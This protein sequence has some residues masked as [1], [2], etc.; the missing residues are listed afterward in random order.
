MPPRDSE[1]GLASAALF[2]PSVLILE[3]L[4]KCWRVLASLSSPVRRTSSPPRRSKPSERIPESLT[5]TAIDRLNSVE[6]SQLA[7]A[8]QFQYITVY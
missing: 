7:T 8:I 2:L 6:A 5:W 1:A 3:E 4:P